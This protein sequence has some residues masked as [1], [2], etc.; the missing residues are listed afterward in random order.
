MTS[1][2]ILRSHFVH[3]SREGDP[4][5]PGAQGN[6][7]PRFPRLRSRAGQKSAPCPAP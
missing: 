5:G 1:N 3:E 6:E 7:P 4:P 2:M